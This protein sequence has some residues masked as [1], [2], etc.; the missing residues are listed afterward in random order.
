M[1]NSE[2]KFFS[3]LKGKMNSEEKKEFEDEL[4]RSDN[5]NKEYTEYEKLNNIID[6]T[7]NIHLSKDYSESIITD[8]RKRIESED[9]KR[10]YPMIR[11]AFAS[12]ILIV[13]GYFLISQLNKENPEEIESLLTEFSEAELNSFSNNY[14]YSTDIANNIDDTGFIRIDS[15][16][17]K[18]LSESVVESIGKK[19]LEDILSLSDVANV[20]EYLSD[21]E[22]DIIYAQLINKEIL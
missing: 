5:L 11:Y 8:F 10:S 3:Y 12:I 1:I 18:N 14:D 9:L 6:E 19:S 4:I 13:G 7:K 22:V 17:R 21:I 2:E 16:Y 15:I 20:D